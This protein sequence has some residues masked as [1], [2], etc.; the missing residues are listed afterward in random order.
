MF[1]CYM[2][3]LYYYCYPIYVYNIYNDTIEMQKSLFS[4][5]IFIINCYS[6]PHLILLLHASHIKVDMYMTITVI[7]LFSYITFIINNTFEYIIIIMYLYVCCHQHFY[8][9]NKIIISI[10]IAEMF[11]SLRYRKKKY[12]MSDNIKVSLNLIKDRPQNTVFCG[13]DHVMAP[14]SLYCYTATLF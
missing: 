13:T 4:S 1:G 6:F 7:S 8:T 14:Y 5:V 9:F 10:Y 11:V 2:L 12:R 3:S